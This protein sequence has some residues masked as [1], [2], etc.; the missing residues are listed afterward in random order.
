[1]SYWYASAPALPTLIKHI[2]TYTHIHAHTNIQTH[3]HIHK[4]HTHTH[5]HI[6]STAACQ[7]ALIDLKD[8]MC[9][10]QPL[11]FELNTVAPKN[12]APSN[13][14]LVRKP[15]FDNAKCVFVGNLSFEVK[16][17]VV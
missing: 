14:S 4:I 10:D 16:V 12:T 13:A 7:Q 9:I 11:R 3:T 8:F 6:C 15:L 1:M 17:S 5:I 2:Q